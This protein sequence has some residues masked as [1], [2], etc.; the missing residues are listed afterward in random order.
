MKNWVGPENLGEGS[1]YPRDIGTSLGNFSGEAQKRSGASGKL[2]T[3]QWEDAGSRHHPED[4]TG[5]KLGRDRG[6]V[7]ENVTSPGRTPF[8]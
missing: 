4:L 2:S 8:A 3:L 5:A 7:S 1:P 6:A